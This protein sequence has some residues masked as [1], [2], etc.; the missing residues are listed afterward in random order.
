[1]QL[2]QL[3][4]TD[5]RS[6]HQARLEPAP[7]GLT[8]ITGAN[9]EGKTNLLEAVG[10]LTTLRSFR[11]AP[12]DAL[13]RTGAARAVLRAEARVEARRLLVEAELTPGRRDRVQVNRQP[14]RRTR[15]LLGTLL[16]TVF[17]PDDLEVVKGGPQGRR[18]LLDDL[19]VSLHPR[20]D[21]TRSEVERVLRQRGALLRSAQGHARPPADV[22]ST[23][24]VWDAKLAAAGEA[25][26]RAREGLVGALAP[27]AADAYRQLAAA[28]SR[29]G[30]TGVG[31]A[32]VR[33]WQ[34]SLAEA[35]AAARGDNLR[36]GVSTVG[37][38]R[39]ELVLDIGGLPARTHAS[40]GEQRSLALAL[41]LAGHAVVTGRAG[42]PPILLLDDVFSELDHAR[43]EALLGL[44]PAGQALLTTAGDLPAG[45]DPKAVV[46]VVGG[47]A[48]GE[49]GAT[50]VPSAWQA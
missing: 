39:D 2:D 18:D 45:A 6:Y 21:A 13:V 33:S 5:F 8:V 25:L 37:P 38:H 34:G 9:G 40:Q 41:R 15:D 43:A 10:Y 32:Y 14:L 47:A 26:V 23:L 36:R 7:D 31:L 28:A 20:H 42:T 49:G 17:A 29:G 48:G 35:L 16:V 24:D 22:I 19:L 12:T 11:G 4:L 3:W 50:L 1:M 27:P 46:R 44:L 30:R